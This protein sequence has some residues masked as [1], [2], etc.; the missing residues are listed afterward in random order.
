MMNEKNHKSKQPRKKPRKRQ[1]QII[2]IVVQT[3]LL[4]TP[5]NQQVIDWANL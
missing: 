2:H 5:V 1:G 3:G 4:V